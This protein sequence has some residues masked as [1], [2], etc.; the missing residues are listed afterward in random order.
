M[1]ERI[2][3][4]GSLGRRGTNRMPDPPHAASA[5]PLQL[6][7]F[8]RSVHLSPRSAGR[9]PLIAPIRA[10]RQNQRDERSDSRLAHVRVARSSGTRVRSKGSSAGRDA[11]TLITITGGEPSTEAGKRGTARSRKGSRLLPLNIQNVPSGP[12]TSIVPE[13]LQP[14]RTAALCGSAARPP[15]TLRVGRIDAACRAGSACQ[16]DPCGY[17]ARESWSTGSVVIGGSWPSWAGARRSCLPR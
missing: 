1:T 8:C 7:A 12:S 5:G 3:H 16:T 6:L 14:S 4:G 17:S 10:L 11:Q 13:S 9:R 15:T 2:P